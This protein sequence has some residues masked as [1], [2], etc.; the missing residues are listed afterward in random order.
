MYLAARP[1]G[2]GGRASD[3]ANVASP[4]NPRDY[5]C[6]YIVSE[7]ESNPQPTPRCRPP[8]SLA[9]AQL[10]LYGLFTQSS[11]GWPGLACGF[12]GNALGGAAYIQ[13]G[14]GCTVRILDRDLRQRGRARARIR[15][16]ERNLNGWNLS[17]Q[18]QSI[19]FFSFS[20]LLSM[21]VQVVVSLVY[22]FLRMLFISC[23]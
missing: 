20:S 10:V 18:D 16:N 14:A 22:N 5:H 11:V 13:H 19:L 4:Q 2:E 7:S 15:T 23:G 21:F 3:I 12:A 1:W 6:C 17:K 8:C 9:R